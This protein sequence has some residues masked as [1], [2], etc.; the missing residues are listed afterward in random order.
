VTIKITNLIA[1]FTIILCTACERQSRFNC[2]KI[3]SSN[4]TGIIKCYSG[5][6]V[7]YEKS[8]YHNGGYLCSI[9]GTEINV[10]GRSEGLC[11]VES[12]QD[13]FWNVP[14]ELKK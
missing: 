10:T 3:P 5:G 11:I 1:T 4:S 7:V 12:R 8:I 6:I 9:D 13:D 2:Y 14:E